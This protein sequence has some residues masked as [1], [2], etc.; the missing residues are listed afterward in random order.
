MQNYS[1][2]QHVNHQILLNISKWSV[3]TKRPI[4]FQQ[5]QIMKTTMNRKGRYP[6]KTRTN[7][8]P[9]MDLHH[10][11]KKKNII[12]TIHVFR[13]SLLPSINTTIKNTPHTDSE[14]NHPTSHKHTTTIRSKQGHCNNRQISRLITEILPEITRN[15]T[16]ACKIT[17]IHKAQNWQT[18]SAKRDRRL[19]R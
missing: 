5:Y 6:T 4:L 11:Q 12:R 7:F 14:K 1:V 10:F 19:L 3:F 13:L 18:L 15:Y 9:K 8:S 16:R 17:Y 2:E